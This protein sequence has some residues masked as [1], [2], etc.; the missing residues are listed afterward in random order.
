MRRSRRGFTLFQLL[1]L[2]AVLAI[3][4][5]LLLPAV[6]KVRQA[7]AR[8]TSINN[9][10]QIGIAVHAYHDVYNKLPSG[11]DANGFS[12]AAHV[13]PFLEQQDVYR[14]IDF[15]KA[16]DDEAN[17][18]ARKAVIKTLLSPQDGVMTVRTDAGAT[19]YLFCA[20][21]QPALAK[22]DGVFCQDT[23]LR[24]GAIAGADGTSNTLLAVE[25]LK[26]DGGTRAVT[27]ARQHVALKKEALEGLKDEA[28]VQ[29]F[30]DSKNI[31]G[32]RCASWMDGG[33]LQGTFTA[34]RRIND[35]RPDVNCAGA[36]GLSGPRTATGTAVAEFCDASVRTI[37]P[38]VKLDVLKALATWN[39]GE[40][41][42]D[43]D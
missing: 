2:I 35:P 39:G 30:K 26:G 7:A 42:K 17:A 9:L 1:V 6:Q 41:I 18:K 37:R 5:G 12:A 31:A 13:L 34:T 22:N 40:E 8:T 28:G 36:G 43:F 27:V 29:E 19:N 21:S 23:G 3:L 15:K 38:D 16:V 24:L 20:G 4:A 11:R 10:K 32:D 33:F 25:T 14:M